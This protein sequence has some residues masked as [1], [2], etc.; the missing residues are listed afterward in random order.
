M[1]Q[2]W[3]DWWRGRRVVF[4][5]GTAGDTRR[6]RCEYQGEQLRLLGALAEATAVEDGA[7]PALANELDSVDCV[8]LHRVEWSAEVAC[9]VAV[10]R[11]RAVPTI[12]DT[13][14]LAFE[15]AA[16]LSWF[17]GF[18]RDERRRS[19]KA[20]QQRLA[21]CSAAVSY[22]VGV[23]ALRRLRARVPEVEIAFFGSSDRE[24][25]DVPFPFRNLGVL[26][27]PAVAQAMNDADILLT[28][29]LTKISKVP[30]EGMACG[31][32]WSISIFRM[33]RAW[34][35]SAL[36][37]SPRS[38]RS[39]SPMLCS[40]SSRIR[41]CGRNWGRA[42]P[43]LSESAHGSAPLHFS[44]RRSGKRCSSGGSP[45]NASAAEVG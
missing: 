35:S 21:E 10:A 40:C 43:M 14:D 38:I 7:A 31:C 26:E 29:S 33:C 13:D 34:S 16:G 6:Y 17:L 20:Q 19:F 44:R 32:A 15:P 2:P 8:I 37:C 18:D 45:A 3:N 27:A 12:F 11:E 30:F 25:G 9:L 22:E 41:R 36:A 23:E 24:L 4:L 5:S 28:F 42:E 1:R 39:S